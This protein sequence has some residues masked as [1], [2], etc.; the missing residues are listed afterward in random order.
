MLLE[1]NGRNGV[2]GHYIP[3]LEKAGGVVGGGGE[4]GSSSQQRRRT[5]A[6]Q[7]PPTSGALASSTSHGHDLSR[8]PLA[9]KS[10]QAEGSDGEGSSVRLSVRDATSR[11][12][13][14]D[15]VLLRITNHSRKVLL[16]SSLIHH[17]SLLLIDSGADSIP[18]E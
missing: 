16:A 15:A 17:E 11:A 2:A 5:A 3:V 13:H 12:S 8:V 4:L 7:N 9:P 6:A 18:T 14:G 1:F 10:S